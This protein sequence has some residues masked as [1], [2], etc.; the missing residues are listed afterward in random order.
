MRKNMLKPTLLLAFTA[1][2]STAGF[3]Q[4]RDV[5]ENRP[6]RRENVRDRREDNRDRADGVRERREDKRDRADGVRERRENRIDSK[7][8]PNRKG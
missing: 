2:L 5:R 6:E 3:A 4:N 1:V 8:L 7:R